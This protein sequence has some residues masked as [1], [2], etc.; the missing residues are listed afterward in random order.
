MC[1]RDRDW[2]KLAEAYG[3]VG[4][5]VE[6]PADVIP[7][8][9]RALSLPKAV[10]IDFLVDPTENVLP[11][12]PPGKALKDMVFGPLGGDGKRGARKGK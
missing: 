3:V 7:A 4:M 1:I 11:M 10:I 6:R 2:V 9:K 5:K 8:I 12:V